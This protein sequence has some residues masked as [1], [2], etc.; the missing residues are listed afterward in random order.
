MAL[1]GKKPE[2]IEKR[3]KAFFYGAAG[4]GKTTAAISFPRPYLIDTERGAENDQYVRILKENQGAIFQTT[5]FDELINEI[6]SLLSEKHDY[7]TVII[8]PLTTL[9]NDLLDKCAKDLKEKSKEKDATGTEFGRHYTEANKHMKH[10]IKL[11]LRLD[12]NVIITAHAKNEYGKGMEV[13][14]QTYD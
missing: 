1:K 6:K 14:G 12:M 3:L 7:R 5:D 9:Y 4:V 10:L 2:T 8:D 11:L 13:L